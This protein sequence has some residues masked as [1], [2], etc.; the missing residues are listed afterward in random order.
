MRKISFLLTLILFWISSCTSRAASTSTSTNPP[1]DETIQVNEITN[2]ICGSQTDCLSKSCPSAEKCPLVIALSNKAVFDFVKT[3]SECDGCSTQV[4]TPDQGIGKCVEYNLAGDSLSQTVTF[5]VSE[6]CKF[7]YG[8]PVKSSIIVKIGK[9]TSTIESIYPAVAYIESSSY[10]ILDS[11]CLGLSGSGVPLKGCVN[12]LY[13][14]LNWSGY[15]PNSNDLCVCTEN[16][17]KQ[18]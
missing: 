5:W 1:D 13:A 6:Q 18:K 14:P 9:A 12:L 10:C 11:D 17:C 16:Q 15:Y 3:Y 4:F 7:R 2:L 8:D